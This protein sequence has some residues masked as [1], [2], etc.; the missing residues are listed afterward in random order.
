MLAAFVKWLSLALL[1]GASFSLMDLILVSKAKEFG[2]GVVLLL[3][4]LFNSAIYLL[5]LGRK[6]KIT[7]SLVFFIFLASLFSVAGNFFSLRAMKIAE[8]PSY[9][10]TAVFLSKN[11][12]LFVLSLFFLGSRFSLRKFLGFLIALIGLSLVL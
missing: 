4:F 10:S 8:N 7:K 3:I 5:F 1:A 2:E 11:F 6:L 12:M 9:A